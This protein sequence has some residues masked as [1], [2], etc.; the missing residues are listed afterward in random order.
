MAIWSNRPSARIRWWLLIVGFAFH[1]P[2][3]WL[4]FGRTVPV[5][6]RR[7]NLAAVLVTLTS[8]VT[9][10]WLADDW[11]WVVIVWLVGHF[12]WG[13]R[14]AWHLGQ[15]VPARGALLTDSDDEP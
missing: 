14:L 13:A 1:A 4:F 5:D 6:A 2:G 7:E 11:M 15:D 12:S 8:I 10:A 3:L 9:A